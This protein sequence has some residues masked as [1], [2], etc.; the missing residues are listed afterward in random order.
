MVGWYVVEIDNPDFSYFVSR[1][2]DKK[3]SNS[4]YETKSD[5]EK[6]FALGF[7]KQIGNIELIIMSIGATVFF[8][9]LLV[10]SNTMEL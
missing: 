9:L 6:A 1:E 7:V 5:T 2:I 10:T 8:T 3:F 4:S